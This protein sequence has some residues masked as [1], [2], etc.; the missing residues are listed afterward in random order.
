MEPCSVGSCVVYGD[1][2]SSS[3]PLLIPLFSL[4]L[5]ALKIFFLPLPGALRG[6]LSLLTRGVVV[7]AEYNLKREGNFVT[8]AAGSLCTCL[9]RT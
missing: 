7:L 5:L 9:R 6:I 3:V 1:G 4:F 8:S 2:K